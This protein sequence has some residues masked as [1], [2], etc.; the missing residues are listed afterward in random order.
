MDDFKKRKLID[1]ISIKDA[2]IERRNKKIKELVRLIN[3]YKEIFSRKNVI[4]SN[5]KAHVEFVQARIIKI[6][7]HEGFIR[8]MACAECPKGFDVLNYKRI[9]NL[10]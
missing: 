4:I 3:N 5:L 8:V 2:S 9:H 10:K 6:H 7:G 1:T